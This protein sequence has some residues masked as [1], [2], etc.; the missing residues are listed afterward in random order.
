MPLIFQMEQ[1]PEI[2]VATEI[3]TAAVT[4]V[5]AV[6]TAIGL[7]FHMTQVHRPTAALARTAIY[8]HIV[9]EI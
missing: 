2:M 5:T 4:A 1:G 6:R 8:F 9:Y 7:V 3:Y